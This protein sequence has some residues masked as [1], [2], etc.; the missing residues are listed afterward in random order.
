MLH[1]LHS[2]H[3]NTLTRTVVPLS[4]NCIFIF[5]VLCAYHSLSFLLLSTRTLVHAYCISSV[6]PILHF[7]FFLL[8]IPIPCCC[9]FQLHTCAA[10]GKQHIHD[11][12]V[13][14]FNIFL[15]LAFR[16]S[17]EMHFHVRYVCLARTGSVIVTPLLFY[18][19]SI[20]LCFHR[21]PN[22]SKHMENED[23]SNDKNFFNSKFKNC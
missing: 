16:S 13:S 10:V 4:L 9:F 21:F 17:N 15:Q 22:T 19:A 7:D 3:T 2:A 14:F 23:L 20:T 6:F 18:R 11:F 1:T 8:C 5:V 12:S